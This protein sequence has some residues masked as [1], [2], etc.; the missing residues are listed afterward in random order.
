M[1][2][3]ALGLPLDIAKVRYS[4]TFLNEDLEISYPRRPQ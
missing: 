2:T 3:G 4:V 1:M